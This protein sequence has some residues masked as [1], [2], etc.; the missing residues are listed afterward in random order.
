MKTSDFDFALPEERI[1]QHPCPDRLDAR[2]MV[3]DRA[4]GRREHAR[5]RDLP[6]WIRSNDLMVFND[7]RVIPARV[8]ARKEAS[9][10]KVEI[11]FLRDRGGGE[12]EALLR[13]GSKRPQI[14]DA[15]GFGR[16]GEARA[17]FLEQLDLGRCRLRVE[18]ETPMA[19]LLERVGET[20]LPPYIRRDPEDQAS[21][22]ADRHRYQTVFAR[23]PGAVAAPTAGLHFTPEILE[24]L[25]AAGAEIATV[26]LHVGL[27]TFRPV[28]VDEVEEHRMEAERYEVPE[29][30][31]ARMRAA[32]AIGGRIITVGST[33]TR[34]LETMAA[35]HPEFAA[36]RGEI[37]I[38]P[39]Q[40]PPPP[41][42][43]GFQVLS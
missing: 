35:R 17:V 43:A 19:E 40:R 13:A 41:D 1:A 24:Q 22:A 14:G 6:R 30:T 21:R 16:P 26:T 15:L 8:R 27:G 29:D 33:T 3:L 10:G 37:C 9:G 32:R 5:V 34:T 7:T 28:T 2:L 39:I 23:E 36:D 18:S 11:F 42:A 4:T 25:R 20:P 31:A 12:W 38:S